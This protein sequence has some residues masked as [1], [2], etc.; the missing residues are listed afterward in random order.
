MKAKCQIKT[1]LQWFCCL[2]IAIFFA[3]G[4]RIFVLCSFHITS[5]SMYPT[6]KAGDYVLVNKQIPGPRVYRNLKHIRDE[7]GKVQTKRFKGIRKIR[8]NDII[9][10][11]F[12]YTNLEKIEMNI[13]LNYLK[14]CVGLP[15]DSFAI[16]N[17]IYKILNAPEAKTGYRP[18]QEQLSQQ[19]VESR[20]PELC[21]PHDTAHFNWNL[22]DFGP[23]YIPKSGDEI[24]IDTLNYLLYRHLIAYETGK[25]VA[26]KDGKILLGD[27]VI[28]TYRFE[29]N[30]YFMAGD[31]VSDSV[32]SRYWGLVPEDHI[33]GKAFMVW[34]SRDMRTN[35]IRW[36]RIFKLL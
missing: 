28:R 14:R 18:A 25:E 21:F 13:D 5:G 19:F 8:R 4:L 6:I 26:A 33:V 10:F 15:G 27:S 31:Y 36:K 24:A 9:A 7:N 23:L 3:I 17:G 11:N 22:R 2:F 12:P 30:Y 34:N 20:E 16:E 35:K 29:M 32:D 1:C